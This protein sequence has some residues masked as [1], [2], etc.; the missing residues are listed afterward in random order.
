MMDNFFNI[1]QHQSGNPHI[2]C[3]TILI[4]TEEENKV[5]RDVINIDF[6][7]K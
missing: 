4:A 3:Y 6:V 7:Q 5:V 1:S 2:V